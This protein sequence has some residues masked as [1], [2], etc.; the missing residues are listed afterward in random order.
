MRLQ[1]EKHAVNVVRMNQ[2][3]PIGTMQ[4][5][6]IIGQVYPLLGRLGGL[7]GEVRDEATADQLYER[8]AAVRGRAQSA[9]DRR[10]LDR[11]PSWKSQ[12]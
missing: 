6:L 12:L 1:R 8:I 11:S 9:V 4:A 3:L 10:A 7:L 5:R 2:R